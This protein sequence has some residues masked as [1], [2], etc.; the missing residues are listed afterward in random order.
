M[1]LE[2]SFKFSGRTGTAGVKMEKKAQYKTKQRAELQEY[3]A[4]TKGKHFTA[5]DICAHFK[6]REKHIGTTTVYRRLEELVNAGEVKKYFIDE[7][8]SACFEYIGDG[9]PQAERCAC[10][11]LKCEKCGRLIHLECDEIT[12]LETHITEHHGFRID[13]VRTVFY[14]ICED[15]ERTGLS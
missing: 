10:Y 5:A 12:A 1:N 11:H 6:N 14:G 4:S 3:L 7:T 15:C 8:S 2:M 13:P 9:A